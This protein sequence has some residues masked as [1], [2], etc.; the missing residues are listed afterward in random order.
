MAKAVAVEGDVSATAGTMPFTGAESGAW[1]PRNVM[2][3][4]YADLKS[5][6]RK[7]LWQA[8]CTFDFIGQSSSGAMV[9]GSET[10]TL[11]AAPTSLKKSAH[12]VVVDGDQA[13]GT[14]GNKLTSSAAGPLKTT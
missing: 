3:N 10:V 5:G 11:T 12:F 14:Y 9:K 2:M 4:S 6:G 8:Q 1:T 13:T 7:V